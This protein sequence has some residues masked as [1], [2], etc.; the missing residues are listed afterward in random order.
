MNIPFSHRYY[1]RLTVNGVTTC[2]AVGV[3]EAVMQ[4]AGYLPNVA[5]PD[6]RF[7]TRSI[8]HSSSATRAG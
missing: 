7:S 2:S 5:G 6:R 8:A 1:I 4:R 3:F